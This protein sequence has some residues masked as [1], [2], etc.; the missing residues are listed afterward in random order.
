MGLSPKEY[1]SITWREYVLMWRAYN[2]K[3]TLAYEHTRAICFTMASPYMKNKVSLKQ[4]WPLDI[5]DEEVD[6]DEG[7]KRLEAAKLRR[8]AKERIEQQKG[9][10]DNIGVNPAKNKTNG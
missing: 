6:E 1:Y 7:K 4:F 8:K 10:N 5:D 2:K 9:K 3:R